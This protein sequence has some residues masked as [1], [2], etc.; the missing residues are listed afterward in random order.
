MNAEFVWIGIALLVVVLL[1]GAVWILKRIR[2][3]G[4]RKKE[5]PAREVL[6]QAR[7]AGMTFA[8][9]SGA[10]AEEQQIR[11]VCVAMEA[12]RLCVDIGPGQHLPNWEGRSVH[13]HFCESRQATASLYTFRTSVLRMDSSTVGRLLELAMPSTLTAV[14]RRRFLRLAPREG[15]ILDSKLWF[16]PPRAAYS[17]SILDIACADLDAEELHVENISAGG[18]SLGL[19]TSKMTALELA[20]ASV[21][22][23]AIQR[24]SIAEEAVAHCVQNVRACQEAIALVRLE[25]S[26]H[27]TGQIAQTGTSCCPVRDEQAKQAVCTLSDEASDVPPLLMRLVLRGMGNEKPLTLWFIGKIVNRRESA[28]G[29]ALGICFLQW[30]QSEEETS[31]HWFPVH[32]EVGVGSLEKWVTR[33]HHEMYF[34]LG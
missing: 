27:T 13:V 22:Q 21:R 29:V 18:V 23:E 2:P 19:S 34:K 8:I 11:G 1:C 6:E 10:D 28:E 20:L 33:R 16:I 25:I 4:K 3:R 24:A 7:N 14:Q 5:R 17:K 9:R 26:T 31:L 30:A 32:P 15:I 12:N